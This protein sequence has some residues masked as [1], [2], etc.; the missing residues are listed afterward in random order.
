MPKKPEPGLVERGIYRKVLGDGT[1]RYRVSYAGVGET[2]DGTLDDARDKRDA[3]RLASR[4]GNPTGAKA[5]NLT[6]DE[7]AQIWLKDQETKAWN[8]WRQRESSYRCHIGP[9]L[10]A[11]R[12]RSIKSRHIKDFVYSLPLAPTTIRTMLETLTLM[13]NDAMAEDPPLVNRNPVADVDAPKD[14]RPE[15]P[16]LRAVEVSRLIDETE[17]AYRAA[18]V[19]AAFCGLRVAEIFG[20]QRYDLDNLLA[21]KPKL[22]VR[23]KVESRP[24]SPATLTDLKTTNSRRDIPIPK[25][26]RAAVLWH[27][28]HQPLGDDDALFHTE[29]ALVKASTMTSIMSRAQRGAGI[30][31][32]G[33]A[34][35]GLRHFYASTLATQGVSLKTIAYLL[36]SHEATVL[37]VYLHM[38]PNDNDRVVG[39]LDDLWDEMEDTARLSRDSSPTTGR[40]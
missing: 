16:L 6:V 9:A 5:K 13:F 18:A 38:A 31:R 2:I 37:R 34:W 23:R 33:D 32:V 15:R 21:R 40:N 11:M 26:A 17:D 7:W 3:M 28:E 4:S 35:H 1:V 27:L 12:L 14:S 19:I 22:R 10:G 8:T 39:L 29:G 25:A 24:Y 36:G 20:L 30:T